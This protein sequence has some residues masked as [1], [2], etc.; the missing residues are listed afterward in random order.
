MGDLNLGELPLDCLPLEDDVLSLELDTC[1]RDCVVDGD[2]TA[3]FYT[4][5]ALIRLQNMFGL[6]PRMQVRHA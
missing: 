2:S 3:L 6:I 1:F 4:A 5:R